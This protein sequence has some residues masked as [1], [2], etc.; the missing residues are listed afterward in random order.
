MKKPRAK[1]ELKLPLTIWISALIPAV[2]ADIYGGIRLSVALT[3]RDCYKDLAEWLEIEY[4]SIRQTKA[5]LDQNLGVSGPF[6]IKNW[7]VEEQVIYG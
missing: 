3:E 1:P 7:R 2:G 6:G 4:V 5:M